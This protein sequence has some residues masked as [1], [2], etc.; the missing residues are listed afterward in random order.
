[1][2]NRDRLVF[3]IKNVA[4][5][6]GITF[7]LESKDGDT[8]YYYS[9]DFNYQY[10]LI[11]KQNSISTTPK[12]LFDYNLEVLLSNCFYSIDFFVNTKNDDGSISHR[13]RSVF[14]EENG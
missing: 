6:K 3:Y 12:T 8:L 5:E 1:M 11:V 7:Y 2:D 13:E 4:E 9:E 10:N 14:E